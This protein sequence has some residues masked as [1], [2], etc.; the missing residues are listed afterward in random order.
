MSF[1]CRAVLLSWILAGCGGA[2]TGPA[3]PVPAT[4]VSAPAPETALASSTSRAAAD[5]PA[6]I[7]LAVRAEMMSADRGARRGLEM[8]DKLRSGEYFAYRVRVDRDAFVYVVQFFADGSAQ[9]LFPPGPPTHLPAGVETRLP[10]DASM[11]FQLDESKGTEHLY[12]IASAA[13]LETA[14]AE[15]AR[16]VG[17]VRASPDAARAP[18]AASASDPLELDEP[19]HG[20][21]ARPDAGAPAVTAS[22]P[23]TPP[24]AM[25]TAP[26]SRY[27]HIRQ[28][29]VL[30]V[31][32]E[33][34][35]EVEYRGRTGDDGVGIAHFPFEHE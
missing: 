18:R 31:R 22:P 4:Q 21:E 33:N 13:P 25:R 26:P 17:D 12:I 7:M 23:A 1:R 24:V 35:G 20:L 34:G 27:A 16:V 30:L 14:D 15:L 6:A 32:V 3:E 10:A 28:R 2:A 29:K 8:G 19:W 11:W 5:E 9:L